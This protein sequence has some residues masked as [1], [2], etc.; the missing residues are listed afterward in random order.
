M[1]PAG[2]T[3]ARTGVLPQLHRLTAQVLPLPYQRLLLQ[4]Q[5]V[6]YGQE[7]TYK[8]YLPPSI[9][10]SPREHYFMPDLD[11]NLDSVMGK[12]SVSAPQPALPIGER[13]AIQV[14]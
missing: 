7:A 11:L 1:Q 12:L 6:P 3:P 5:Q 4:A 2:R 9:E 10:T 13:D 8:Q 14:L